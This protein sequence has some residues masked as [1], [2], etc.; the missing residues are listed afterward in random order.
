MVYCVFISYR[1]LQDMDGYVCVVLEV[2]GDGFYRSIGKTGQH[3]KY[4]RD[5]WRL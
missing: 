3:R 1:A 4:D 5:R 2:L